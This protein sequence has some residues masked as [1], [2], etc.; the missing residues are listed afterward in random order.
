LPRLCRSNPQSSADCDTVLTDVARLTGA[1]ALQR[2]EREK[3]GA[4]KRQ[5]TGGPGCVDAIAGAQRAFSMKERASS[6]EHMQEQC[7]PGAH[8]AAATVP[9]DADAPVSSRTR[10]RN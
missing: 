1:E 10:K 6:T 2:P 8:H 9:A 7:S 4:A 5:R 3:R